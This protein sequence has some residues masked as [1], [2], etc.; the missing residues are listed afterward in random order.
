VRRAIPDVGHALSPQ[1]GGPI[2]CLCFVP[3]GSKTCAQIQ[4]EP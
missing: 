4:S 1:A 2:L 3:A